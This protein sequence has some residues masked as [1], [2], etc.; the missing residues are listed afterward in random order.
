MNASLKRTCERCSVPCVMLKFHTCQNFLGENLFGNIVIF[1]NWWGWRIGDLIWIVMH[2]WQW[3]D[4]NDHLKYVV[5]VIAFFGWKIAAYW[6]LDTIQQ[7]GVFNSEK[8]LYKDCMKFRGHSV[9]WSVKLWPHPRETTHP[10]QI[11][12][13]LILKGTVLYSDY[14]FN[15]MATY[16]VE[17]Y[18]NFFGPSNDHLD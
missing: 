10:N 14:C 7:G 16:H 11:V 8:A 3:F 15:H 17:T 13:I 4:L 9:I 12:A 2:M 6:K 5:K 18:V 1:E